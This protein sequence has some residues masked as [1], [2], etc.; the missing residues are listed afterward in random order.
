MWT[1]RLYSAHCNKNER[2]FSIRAGVR[3]P[4]VSV[5]HEQMRR[6]QILDAALACF[7]RRGYHATSMEDIVREAGLS[8]GAIY[9][10]FPSK[11]ELF[12]VLAEARF[13]HTRDR[14]QALVRQGDTLGARLEY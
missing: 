13:R 14:I 5:E 8:V 4:K 12:K 7:S 11:E 1:P 3:V 2:S 9:T 6:Q 10:Y